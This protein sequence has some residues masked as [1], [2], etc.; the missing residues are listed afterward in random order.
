M[1]E[2]TIGVVVRIKPNSKQKELFHKNFGCVRKVYNETLGKYNIL[3]GENNSIKPTMGLLNSLMMESKA[4][5]SYLQ[6]TESTS[7]QQSVVDL[8]SAFNLF[9]KNPA[10]NYPKFHSKKET[11]PSFRQ[12]IPTKKKII[13]KNKLSLRKYG[14]ISFQTSPEYRKLL[15]SNDIKFNNVTIAYDGI[16]YYAIIN[17]IKDNPE[18]FQLT[19]EKIGC[20]I[21]SNINGWLVTSEGIKEFF[22]V[23]HENQMIRHIN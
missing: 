4:E 10:H 14:E 9:F 20:D 22:D 18:Q 1:D 16:H 15:N 23:N 11:L 12:T 19:G 7:L 8:R 6:E 17:I 5:L 2:I 13:N 3:Y 21:N